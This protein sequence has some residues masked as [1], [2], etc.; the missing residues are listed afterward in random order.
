MHDVV[1]DKQDI[2]PVRTYRSR[3]GHGD[4]DA[5]HDHNHMYDRVQNCS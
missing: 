4:D 2:H 3:Y 1:V 5:Y